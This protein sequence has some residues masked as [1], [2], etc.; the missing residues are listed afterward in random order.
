M[1]A[2][3]SRTIKNTENIVSKIKDCLGLLENSSIAIIN[4]EEEKKKFENELNNDFVS[5][6]FIKFLKQFW[7][8][9][10]NGELICNRGFIKIIISKYG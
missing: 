8:K 7:N 10:S 4:K 6:V 3:D 9:Y 1:Q 2:N 5:L